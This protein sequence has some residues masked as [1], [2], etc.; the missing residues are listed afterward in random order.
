MDKEVNYADFLNCDKSLLIAPAGHGKTHS[1]TECVKLIDDKSLILTHSNAG[2]A[3]LRDK[4]KHSKIDKGK[5]KITTIDG[6]ARTIASSFDSKFSPDDPFCTILD[7]AIKLVNSN[8]IRQS[9]EY[10]YRC[11]FVDEYQDCSAK[12]HEFI[13]LISRDMPTHLFGDP[14]QG[15]FSFNGD[16]VSFENDL[17]DYTTFNEL[18]TPHRWNQSKNPNLGEKILGFR[19]RILSNEPI[20][21]ATDK[22]CHLYVFNF[23]ELDIHGQ[24]TEYNKQLQHIVRNYKENRDLDSLLIIMPEYHNGTM[25]K[26][27]EQDRLKLK[28]RIDFKDELEVLLPVSRSSSKKLCQLIDTLIERKDSV[29]KKENRIKND[30]LKKLF[31]LTSINNWFNK[32]GLK[33]KNVLSDKEKSKLLSGDIER[34]YE[35]GTSSSLLDILKTTK[36]KMKV[37]LKN[38]GLYWDILTLLESAA[39]S[40]KPLMEEFESRMNLQRRLGRKSKNKCIGSTLLTK[41]LEYDTVVIL[42]AHRITCP[43]NLYVALSRCCKMLIVFT[44]TKTLNPNY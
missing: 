12:Q 28:S 24:R 42:D 1:I 18:T 40:E 44:E 15:I 6:F 21:I 7:K 26:G 5:Y 8:I 35:Y 39:I 22:T 32:D 34:F 23:P 4:L 30:I 2:V 19:K 13:Q 16:I 9:L 25:Q 43:K 38:T 36:N 41:G 31:N 33:R 37:K 27:G 3:A 20:N 11:L 17:T 29:I 14:L 10:N